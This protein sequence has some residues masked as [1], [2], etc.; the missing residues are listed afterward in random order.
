MSTEI[1]PARTRVTPS[2][3]KWEAPAKFLRQ[4]PPE[5]RNIPFVDDK[6]YVYADGFDRGVAVALFFGALVVIGVTIWEWLQ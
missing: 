6:D 3:A 4:S 1:K 5:H 2:F